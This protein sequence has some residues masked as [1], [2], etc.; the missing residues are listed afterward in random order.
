[1]RTSGHVF[2]ATSVDGYI[3]RSNGDIG[4]LSRYATGSEDTG[5]EAFMASVDGLVM[6]RGTFE[7]ALS[8]DAWPYRK[9]VVVLSR[10]LSQA[11]IP[12]D[13]KGKVSISTLAPGA[14][15][16]ALNAAGWRR[17]YVDGGKVIQAFLR[18]TLI[19]DIILTRVPVLLGSG[20]PLFGALTTDLALRHV[21]T[22]SFASGLVQTTYEV[23]A[24]MTAARR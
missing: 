21:T 18:D 11:D 20:I 15:M 5:Y 10:A 12:N 19:S 2:I 24:A 17:A 14:L 8:F 23:T 22:R 3:A 7:T 4:W 13:L 9:P 16:E 1:M 6:G